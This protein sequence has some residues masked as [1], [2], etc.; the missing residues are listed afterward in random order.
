LPDFD[1]GIRQ[2]STFQIG[3]LPLCIE[4]FALPATKHQEQCDDVLQL[5][6]FA[7]LNGVAQALCFLLRQK[8][9]STFDLILLRVGSRIDLGTGNAELLRDS[10]GVTNLNDPL[11]RHSCRIACLT[12]CHLFIDD[13]LLR[14]FIKVF[15]AEARLDVNLPEAQVGAHVP[16]RILQMRQVRVAIQ[17]GE[18]WN[19]AQLFLFFDGAF[20]EDDSRPQFLGSGSGLVEADGLSPPQKQQQQPDQE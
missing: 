11:V 16:A 13:L 9:L 5:R 4:Q 3:I 19:Q 12:H 2:L 1:N 18:G 17:L 15:M 7:L 8:A 6:I 14:Y 10:V 20:T